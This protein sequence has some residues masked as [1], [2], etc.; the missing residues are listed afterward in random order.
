MKKIL[1]FIIATG[2]FTSV[3]AQKFYVQGGLN[4][5]NITT[6]NNGGTSDN[7]VLPTFNAGAMATFGISPVFDLE[8][9]LLFTG[10]G[11]KFDVFLN[12][13][14]HT[15]NYF[16]YKFNPYYIELPVNAQVKFPLAGKKSSIFVSA[17]PYIAMGVAGKVKTETKI[18]GNVVNSSSTI[19]FSNSSQ[20][21]N[22]QGQNFDEIKR[23]DYG[24]N[25]GAGIDF[26]HFIIKAGY[27]LGLAKINA[28]Q[29]NNNSNDKNKYRTFTFSIG[30]PLGN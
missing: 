13:N 17:G 2:L 19:K 27:G 15:D 16:K 29:T 14:D 20:T 24:A 7:N 5:A 22:Q 9:G 23:F 12:S 21:N 11:S 26:G 1:A 30:I 3:H 18:I 4:L 25:F 10:R 8:T 6:T 28:S